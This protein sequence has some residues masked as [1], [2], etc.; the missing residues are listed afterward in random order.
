ME[1]P[2]L[3]SY[4]I[5][6]PGEE[7]QRLLTALHFAELLPSVFDSVDAFLAEAARLDAGIIILCISYPEGSRQHDLKRIEARCSMPVMAVLPFLDETAVVSALDAGADDCI[8]TYTGVAVVKARLAALWLRFSRTGIPI[9]K[10]DRYQLDAQRCSITLDGEPIKLNTKSYQLAAL[11]LRRLNEFVP[12]DE[13]AD[14]VWHKEIMKSRTLDVHTC[15]LRAALHW[16]GMCGLKL[17]AVY[18]K[19]LLLHRTSDESVYETN[20]N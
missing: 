3:N 7:R 14:E 9:L 12:R 2:N 17:R 5:S 1:Q 18:G 8:A 19:G 6:V 10:V 15:G 4:L 20:E 13:I 16:D 11:M